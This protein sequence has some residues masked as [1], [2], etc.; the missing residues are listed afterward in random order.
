MSHLNHLMWSLAQPPTGGATL[1][2]L[3]FCPGGSSSGFVTVR[4]A[5][6]PSPP[7][8]D[9]APVIT[10][11]HAWHWGGS[12]DIFVRFLNEWM[13]GVRRRGLGSSRSQSFQGAPEER[14]YAEATAAFLFAQSRRRRQTCDRHQKIYTQRYTTTTTTASQTHA[15]VDLCVWTSMYVLMCAHAY[16]HVWLGPARPFK[17][18]ACSSQYKLISEL[19]GFICVSWSWEP[20]EVEAARLRE[21]GKPFQLENTSWQLTFLLASLV[22]DLPYIHRESW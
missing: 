13:N 20:S 10:S 12:S 6:M 19:R 7:P 16:T 8:S 14:R 22:T 11:M 18:A 4:A 2:K 9:C 21:V 1:L 15:T 3:H 17:C 5:V